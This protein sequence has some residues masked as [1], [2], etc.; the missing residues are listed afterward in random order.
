MTRGLKLA[1][2]PVSP[3]EGRAGHLLL[4]VSPTLPYP[5]LPRPTELLLEFESLP[6]S[7]SNLHDEVVISEA[8]LI[9]ELG[10]GGDGGRGER[11][12]LTP[13]LSLKVEDDT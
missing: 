13:T 1:P 8:Y 2:V 9:T 11:E 7:S 5:A 12:T 3:P 6:Y 10:V 4:W